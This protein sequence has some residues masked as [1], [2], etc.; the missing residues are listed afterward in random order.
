LTLISAQPAAS[1]RGLPGRAADRYR[2]ARR[3]PHALTHG[4]LYPPGA[5][6]GVINLQD[7]ILLL[8][9]VLQ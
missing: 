4:D 8:Q 3:D 9:R 5:P 6:D 7:V 1:I 2:A